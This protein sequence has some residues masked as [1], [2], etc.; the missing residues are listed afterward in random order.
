MKLGT[1]DVSF[2]LNTISQQGD[3]VKPEGAEIKN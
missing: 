1:N 2:V 3:E